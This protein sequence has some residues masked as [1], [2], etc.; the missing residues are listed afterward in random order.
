MSLNALT[1]QLSAKIRRV[2]SPRKLLQTICHLATLLS[3]PPVVLKAMNAKPPDLREH[4]LPSH[5]LS[6]REM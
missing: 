3:P 4:L 5:S 6:F 1:P 2:I